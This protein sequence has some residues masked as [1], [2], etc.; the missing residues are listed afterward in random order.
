M[1]KISME[2]A[3]RYRKQWQNNLPIAFLNYRTT[4]HSSTDCELSRPFLGRVP[5]SILD[6]KLGLRFNPKIAPTTDLADEQLLRTKNLCDQTEENVMQSNI[7]YKIYYDKQAKSSP[8][9]EKDHSFIV[10]K[11]IAPKTD[12]QGSE[13]P[14][15]DIQWIGRI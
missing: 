3:F 14:F 4:Y 12:H 7:K 5:Q 6:H 2:M 10:P 9:K 1:I 13:L 8:L 11:V 15:C